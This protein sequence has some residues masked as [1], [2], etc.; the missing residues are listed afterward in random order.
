MAGSNTVHQNPAGMRNQVL[1]VPLQAVR[2]VTVPANQA[3]L[4]RGDLLLFQKAATPAVVPIVLRH[5]RLHPEVRRAILHRGAAAPAHS[6]E[7]DLIQEAAEVTAAEAAATEVAGD[8]KV[9][10]N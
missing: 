8:A 1:T 5:I 4:T 6:P 3:L 10:T 7:A 9:I 2:Q